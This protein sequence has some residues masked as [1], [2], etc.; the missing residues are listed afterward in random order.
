MRR[1]VFREQAY[2]YFIFQQTHEGRLK[3]R[4]KF[5]ARQTLRTWP[6]GSLIKFPSTKEARH[7]DENLLAIQSGDLLFQL[8]QVPFHLPGGVKYV[9]DFLEFWENG[10]ILFV[11]AKGR[12]LPEYIRNMKLVEALYPIKITEV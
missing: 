7:Y 1:G 11:D 4:H 8:R 6:D 3:L 9:L 5:N 12:R 2:R 10:E